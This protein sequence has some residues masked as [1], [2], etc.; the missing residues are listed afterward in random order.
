MLARTIETIQRREGGRILAGLIRRCGNFD[1][2]EDALQ[3]AYARALN[4]WQK[5]GLPD[6]PAAWLTR[7]AQ[8]VWLDRIRRDKNTDALTDEA[9]AQI[10]DTTVVADT[11][12]IEDDQLRLIFTCCHPALAPAAQTALA[13][14][15]ICQLSVA[16]IARAYLESETAIAQRL[17]RAKRKI[18][19]AKI[20]Y[21]VPA[22]DE[23]PARLD[24]VLQVIYLVFNEGYVASQATA[25]TLIRADLCV[26]AIRLAT[27]LNTLIPNQAEAM[28]LAALMRLID[29]R[30]DAR[31]DANGDLIPLDE[32]DR[33]A[34]HLDSIAEATKLL[35]SALLLRA[36][37]AYQIE[38][39]IAALHSNAA[40][41]AE[42]DWAQISAL[43][44]ALW[45]HRPTDIVAL[46]AAVAHAMAFSIDE[47]LVRID[48][49]EAR[50]ELAQYH[51]LYAARADLLRRQGRMDKARAAYENAISHCHNPAE[52]RYLEKRLRAL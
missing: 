45:R 20:P 10:A 42:T 52:K 15:T 14:K 47:G 25:N 12:P 29:A 11:E 26:E 8:R 41:A 46:N 51:L 32:Q 21:V 48:R 33:G 7:V 40:T 37:G 31:A 13:L 19:D 5:N 28:G 22:A 9:I 4:D 18:A 38:A 1:I 6:N 16:E 2:A 50:G 49:I 23:L 44:G 34:W 36:P 27:L 24:A 35:D 39:A 3:E 17:V 30:R 43:Y